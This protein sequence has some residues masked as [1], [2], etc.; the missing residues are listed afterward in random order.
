MT[1]SRHV[2]VHAKRHSRLRPTS[3]RQ[4]VDP[5]QFT[6]TLGV[7]GTHVHRNRLI[8]LG[9]ALSNTGEDDIARRESR[10][11]SHLDLT[12]RIGIGT[13][14]KGPDELGDRECRVRL[15]RIVNPMSVLG[16]RVI[17]RR[18]PL[19]NT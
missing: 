2:R 19:G 17:E 3:A 16:E 4:P 1:P 13:T 14:A 12:S 6:A 9:P 8:Q 5:F 10:P 7:D 11:K 18:V 15:E